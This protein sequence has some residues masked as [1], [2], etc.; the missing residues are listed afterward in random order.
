MRLA[1]RRVDHRGSL[2]IPLAIQP[3]AQQR[4]QLSRVHRLRDVVGR[5]GLQALLAV[6]LHGLRGEG[7][8]RQ[9]PELRRRLRISRIVS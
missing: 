4:Q 7:E 5:A 1:V 2:D 3:D 9:R 6:A 8:D